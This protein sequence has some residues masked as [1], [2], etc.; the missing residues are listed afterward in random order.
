MADT[1]SMEFGGMDVCSATHH[2]AGETVSAAGSGDVGAMLSSA[3]GAI[4]PAGAQFHS[5]LARVLPTHMN[6]V[7]QHSKLLHSIGEATTSAKATAIA[8]DNG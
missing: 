4:R 5:V 2:A 8:S 3:A 6:A 1:F 7:Q